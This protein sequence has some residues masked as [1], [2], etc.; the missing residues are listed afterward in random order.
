MRA[1]AHLVIYRR[2]QPFQPV[3]IGEPAMRSLSITAI[4]SVRHRS[5]LIAASQKPAN[6]AKKARAE[7]NLRRL[8]R[9]R[10]PISSASTH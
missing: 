3:M 5:I 7:S 9:S 4:I 6:A 2:T 8:A 10:G 1:S